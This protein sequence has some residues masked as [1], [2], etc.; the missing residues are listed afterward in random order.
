M[1][2]IDVNLDRDTYNKSKTNAR[3]NACT[4]HYSVR[5]KTQLP[6]KRGITYKGLDIDGKH[7]YHAYRF[8]RKAFDAYT[9]AHDV[10]LLDYECMH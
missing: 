9:L 5:S 6:I 4:E 10:L 2:V 7:E 3:Y 8:T 1:A